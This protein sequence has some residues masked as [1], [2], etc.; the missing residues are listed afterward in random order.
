LNDH[1]LS[2]AVTSQRA[3]A[4]ANT[5]VRPK[6]LSLQEEMLLEA[7][8]SV[9]RGTGEEKTTPSVSLLDSAIGSASRNGVRAES[10]AGINSA[11]LRNIVKQPRTA[12]S[13][14]Q[15]TSQQSSDLF[16]LETVFTS[17]NR[18]TELD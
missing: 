4:A 14:D 16:E 9:E 7:R 5:T 15:S 10:S 6:K 13:D 2:A 3:K 1:T 18:V 17:S 12:H 11:N 8:A